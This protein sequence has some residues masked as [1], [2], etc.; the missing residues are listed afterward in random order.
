M[1]IELRVENHRSILDEQVLTMETGNIRSSEDTLS[2]RV[3]GYSKTL[4]PA[5]ALYG[6]NASGKSN[7][8]DALNFMRVAVVMSHRSWEPEDNIPT[9]PFAWGTHSK[10]PSFY[11]VSFLEEGVRYQYGFIANDREFIEEWLYAWPKGHKQVWYERN[12]NSYYI[13]DNLKGENRLVID[14]TR[15]NAL[16]LS[17]AAQHSHA[18][19]TKV[20]SWFRTIRMSGRNLHWRSGVIEAPSGQW[21]KHMISQMGKGVQQSLFKDENEIDH[22]EVLELLRKLLRAADFGIVDMRFEEDNMGTNPIRIEK[23]R[24]P[25]HNLHRRIFLKHKSSISDAWLPLAEESHGTVTLFRM[26]PMIIYALLKGRVLAID[27]LEASLHPLLAVQI[28]RMFNNKETNPNNAQLIF[29]THDTNLLGTSF[30][31]QVLRRDQVWLTEKNDA[32]ATILY[33]LTDYKPRKSENIERGYLQGRY[34]S[35]PFIDDFNILRSGD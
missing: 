7:I 23:N 4:L 14:I 2:R 17:A 30:G 26:A 6:A 16:F 20:Y 9:D 31:S 8:L 29:T 13:G 22:E 35:V 27:E 32:G 1:L 24:R 25:A 10:K 34:G 5:V 11:E 33:P 15:P 12:K 19:L 21:M 28:I 18:Q 3:K